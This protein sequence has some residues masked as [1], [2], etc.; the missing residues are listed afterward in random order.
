MLKRSIAAIVVIFLVWQVLDFVIHGVL[1]ME[2]YGKTAELWRP[3]AE[4]KQGLMAVVKLISAACFVGLYALLV[5]P[6][7]LVAGIKYGLILGLG[8]GITMGHGTY[9]YM[10][11]PY[12]LA[13][14]WFGATIVQAVIA[15]ALLGLIVKAA[16]T[17]SETAPRATNTVE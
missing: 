9:T 5:N 10:P 12:H 14:S 4:M 17:G 11:I 2:T 13:L 1:L 16:T 7:S 8:T 3:M 6:K 15:G